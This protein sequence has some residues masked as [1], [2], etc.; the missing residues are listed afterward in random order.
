MHP[1]S[2]MLSI[3]AASALR[4]IIGIMGDHGW[5]GATAEDAMRG[6]L[7]D[8]KLIYA[9]SA[10][11]WQDMA[12]EERAVELELEDMGMLLGG[13]S[14]TEVMSSELPWIDMVRWSVDFI[15][16]ELRPNWS[17][18]EWALL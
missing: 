16:A 7:L 12:G 13:L 5:T 2:V 15:A 8:A 3:E 14:F 4:Q 6:E 11:E 1:R 9:W 17:D 10:E 18:E